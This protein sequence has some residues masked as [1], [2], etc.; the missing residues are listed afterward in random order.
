MGG[1]QRAISITVFASGL[2]EGEEIAMRAREDDA[3]R[4]LMT[5]PAIRPSAATALV[6]LA[7][8]VEGFLRGLDFAASL[9]LTPR[10]HSTGGQEWLGAILRMGERKL[11]EPLIIGS[12]AVVRQASK[13]G[14]PRPGAFLLRGAAATHPL[15]LTIG[16]APP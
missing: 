1:T 12:S 7:P 14:E 15:A 13:R 3:F 2:E 16:Q 6:A 4:R 5:I 10:Q 11:R 8:P 9:G